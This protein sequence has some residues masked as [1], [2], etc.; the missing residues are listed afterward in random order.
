MTLTITNNKPDTAPA[1]TVKRAVLYL[2]VSS[3]GQLETDYDDDGLSIAA[4]RERCAQKAAEFGAIVVDEYIE[5]AESAK[6]NQRPELNRM[7]RRIK[8]ERDIDYV[9]CWKV[10]RFAR[11]RRDDANMLFEIELAGA[12]LISATENIDQTPAGRLMHGMLASFAEYYSRNLANE[13]LKGS[14]EKAK[15]GGTLGR[16]RLGYLNVREQL[17]QGGEVRTV[18]IDP[19]R[20]PIIRWAFETYATG[21]YSIA[22]MT[23]LLDARG[24]RTRGDRRRAPQA[25]GQSSIYDMLSSPY[26]AGIVTYRGKSYPGRHE[27][28]ISQEL[29]DRVQAV[30][31][32]HN[33]AGERDRT[34]Q[35]YLKGTIR[36]GTCGC[37]LV[38]SQ[39]KGNGGI[40]EY[41]VCP[42]NQRGECPQGYQPVDIVESAIEHHYQGVAITDTEREEVRQAITHDLN[43]RA[44]LAQQEIDRCRGVLDEVKEQERKLL[45]MHYEDRI[46]GELFDD[47]QTR[48]RQR[49]RDAETL[50]DRLNL[51]Y[52]DI[53]ATLDLALEILGEDL[54]DLY[55]RADDTIRRLLNQAIFK[56]LYVCDETIANVEMTGPFAAL[57]DFRDAIHQL[58]SSTPYPAPAIA[59][60]T[61]PNAKAPIPSRE[62]E[63]LDVGSIS[64]VLVELAGLEPATFWLPARRSPN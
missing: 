48:L 55:Q 18:T 59:A 9:I 21:L 36:C 38:Y 33:H 26:Y 17:P 44:K 5:R 12:R 52:Q 1:D 13:V 51:G 10:D 35:H 23:V 8:E 29:F 16:A 37:R 58:P 19:E 32:S 60:S 64:K 56:A 3:R 41:F 28:L 57:C 22:D 25:L 7:L 6:T 11:N 15:R 31:E 45:N 34:H 54:H 53:A 46:S 50:I 20:A 61:L 63:L 24:L 30:L 62:Q 42:Y 47:E 2:R 43:E 49:R 4:Q 39:N 14:T 27:P 40:Y